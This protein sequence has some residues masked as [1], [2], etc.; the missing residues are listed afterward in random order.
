MDISVSRLNNR[1]ALRVPTELPLGL[2][3]VVGRV[4]NLVP[5]GDEIQFDLVEAEHIIYCRLPQTVASETL[6]KEGDMARASGQLVFD[7]HRAAYILLARDVQ[8]MAEVASG[9][10][11]IMPILSD[12]RK[13]AQATT[14]I[15]AELPQWVKQLAPPE[16]QAE[17]GLEPT[18]QNES[19]TPLL[20]SAPPPLTESAPAEPLSSE[21]LAFLSQA[22]DSESEVELTPS[23]ISKFAPPEPVTVETEEVVAV[24]E[25]TPLPQ[26]PGLSRPEPPTPNPQT[27]FPN[28][29]IIP[30]L[31]GLVIIICLA[32]AFLVARDLLQLF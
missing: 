18:P 9:R 10:A 3:F 32:L 8:I 19:V 14:L 27:T 4:Q 20:P 2:V 30:T 1:M 28:P 22:M 7:P 23:I 17:L 26:P 31:I 16:V 21:M 25:A 13:R 29:L 6:L 11:S 24:N 5:A 12:V 15:R